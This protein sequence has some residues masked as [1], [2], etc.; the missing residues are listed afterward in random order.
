MKLILPTLLIVLACATR[1]A[2]AP[3]TKLF[4]ITITTG[5][6]W[7]AAKPANEQKF[8]REHSA[9]LARLRA[10]NMSVLGGRFSDKGFLIVRAASE[11]AVRAEIAKDP[12]IAA[13]IFQASVDE[14]RAFQHGDT[15]PPLAT[16]EVAVVRAALAAYNTRDAAA[17]AAH[18]ADD[19]KWFG[20][21]GEKTSIEG[22]GRAA[23]EKWLAGYFKSLPNVRAEISDVAQTGPHVSFRERVTWTANDGTRRAQSAIGIYEVRDGKIARAWYFPA[24]REAM[25]PTPAKK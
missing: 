11:P 5:P 14:Y 17:V 13:G 1:A 18:Y 19:I 20:I 22:E 2:D 4:A 23:V 9:N 12:S 24:A 3:A 25:P 21:A 8:F 7:D 16:P 6:A 10:E 15:R